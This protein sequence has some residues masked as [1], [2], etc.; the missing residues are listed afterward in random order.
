MAVDNFDWS[1]VDTIVPLQ[2]PIAV[3]RNSAGGVV[4]RQDQTGSYGDDVCIVLAEKKAVTQLIA[5]LKREICD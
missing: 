1:D 5:A 3:Y 4:I 2:C